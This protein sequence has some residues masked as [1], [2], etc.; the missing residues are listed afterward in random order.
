MKLIQKIT[1]KQNLVL[2]LVLLILMCVPVIIKAT[3][4]QKT[5]LSEETYYHERIIQQIRDTGEITKD[6]VQERNIPIN[7]FYLILAYTY[8]P[9]QILIAIIPLLLAAISLY[10]LL[11]ILKKLEIDEDTKRYGIIVAAI[12]PAIMYAFT[13]FSPKSMIY[14]L[15]LIAIYSAIKGSKL[16]PLV[17]ILLALTNALIAGIVLLLIILGHL[18]GY[19][20]K[21][22]QIR[23]TTIAYIVTILLLLI[24]SKTNLILDFTPT[25]LGFGDL[26]SEFGSLQGY[27]IM[28]IGLAIIGLTSWWSKKTE[29]TMIILSIIALFILSI[30]Y[31]TIIL[32]TV[33]IFSIYA[34]LAINYLIKREWRIEILKNIT[35]LL[36]ICSLIFSMVIFNTTI[37]K[38]VTHE[39]VAGAVQLSISDPKDII[40]S[41]EEN[42]YIIQNLAKRKTY[43]DS[44]SY[45]YPNYKNK[46]QT[47]QEIYYAK[48][49][50][51]LNT[52]LENNSIKYILLDSDMKQKLWNNKE[53]GLI[54]F[55]E[56]AKDFVKTYVNDEVEIYR[57][58]DVMQDEK[59]QN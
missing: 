10:L 4:S 5:Y 32:I 3:G 54:F 31:P 36:I 33:T 28:I 17:I 38:K 40:L 56:N 6:L 59:K 27:T 7:I 58:L 15:F 1:K 26:F 53:E 11:K 9:T 45:K 25:I 35:L 47:A 14:V 20:K 29:R 41:S 52:Q 34:G 2:L 50:V 44:A 46:T 8:I 42:G 21:E 12:S 30:I 19:G 57:Y 37:I 13:V 49:L 51:E 43:L 55:F 18:L 22:H 48:N 16:T 39:K 23:N 24:L